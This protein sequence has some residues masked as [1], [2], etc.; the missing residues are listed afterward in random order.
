MI[1]GRLR[2]AILVEAVRDPNDADDLFQTM[3]DRFGEIG[4]VVL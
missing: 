2:R 3:L 1:I 4:G